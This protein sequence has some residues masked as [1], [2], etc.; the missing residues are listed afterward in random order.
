MNEGIN[1]I[2]TPP[3]SNK[4]TL[5]GEEYNIYEVRPCDLPALAD[6]IDGLKVQTLKDTIT[7]KVINKELEINFGQF[8]NIIKEQPEA[9]CKL[10]AAILDPEPLTSQ[11]V[12][13]QKDKT[14][15]FQ[16]L[17]ISELTKVFGEWIKINAPFFA[18]QATPI[19]LAI[20]QV[21]ALIRVQIEEKA[22]LMNSLDLGNA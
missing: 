7:A 3:I 1:S 15:Y 14:I 12:N 10:L 18:K 2:F 8:I 20:A 6:F 4:V 11:S 17:P 13:W 16:K 21:M 19:V 9:V 22:L 5:G